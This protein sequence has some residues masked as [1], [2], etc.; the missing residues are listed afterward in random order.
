[1][2]FELAGLTYMGKNWFADE[3]FTNFEDCCVN[4]GI[5]IYDKQLCNILSEKLGVDKNPNNILQVT[6][7]IRVNESTSKVDYP[8]NI[9]VIYANK[10]IEN[11]DLLQMIYDCFNDD[12]NAESNYLKWCIQYKIDELV[13]QTS[14]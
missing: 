10:E 11:I 14:N 3:G 6:S 7:G 12:S 5:Y 9:R 13:K 4:I 1:M 8:N 2:N